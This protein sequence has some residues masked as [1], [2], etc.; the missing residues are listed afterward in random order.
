MAETRKHW[1]ARL[2]WPAL[3]LGILL[4]WTLGYQTY[5]LQNTRFEP[6]VIGTI[7]IERLYNSLKVR[8]NAESELQARAEQLQTQIEQRESEIKRLEEDLNIFE[9]GSEQYRKALEQY[10]L[11]SLRHR[12]RVE[13][14]R[15]ILGAQRALKLRQIYREIKSAVAQYAKENGIDVVFV[16]DSISA[17]PEANEQETMRQISARRMLYAD[18]QVDLTQTI[19]NRMNNQFH[20][21]NQG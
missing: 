3:V 11:K 5:A 18:E 10:S 7:D 12:A 8:E 1:R 16:N 2:N 19:I 6:S 21:D 14:D 15:R 13:A 4:V 17:I 9:P 20:A